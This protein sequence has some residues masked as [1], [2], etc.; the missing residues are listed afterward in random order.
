MKISK[1]LFVSRANLKGAKRKKTVLIMMVL[2]VVAV[3]V[4]V[5]YLNIAT[6]NYNIQLSSIKFRQIEVDPEVVY[7]SVSHKGVNEKT[8][9][10]VLSIDHVVSCE[11]MKYNDYQTFSYKEIKDDNGNNIAGEGSEIDL[12]ELENV[13]SEYRIDEELRVNCAVGQSLK[14]APVM[15]CIIPDKGEMWHSETN[16]VSDYDISYLYGKTLTVECPYKALVYSKADG[17][18]IEQGGYTDE[19]VEL[20]RLTLNLKVVGVYSLAE[21]GTL[22]GSGSVI[23]SPETA[24]TIEDMAVE[25]AK[26]TMPNTIKDY[27]NDPYARRYMVTVDSRENTKEVEEKLWELGYVPFIW[28]IMDSS[29]EQF[30]TMFSGGGTFLLI[31]ILMLTVINL[32][33]SVYS[34][35][36]ERRSEIGLLKAIG[37]K[38]RQIFL[39]MYLENVIQAVRALIIGGVIS[40][41]I[42]FIVNK[43]NVNDAVY[44]KRIFVMQW[45]Q[46]GILLAIAFALILIIPLTCQ[47]I[48]TA[49]ITRIQPQEAMNS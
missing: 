49:L 4:L 43:I 25:E 12:E 5:G 21:Y 37:Y 42:I 32:F 38:S 3:T 36:N 20:A 9:D 17:N 27:V 8:M 18:G 45:S 34:N 19:S 6:Y 26:K 48:M 23:V 24:Q 47:L 13:I 22:T 11:P 30:A 29:F 46:F 41:V 35:I 14:D 15:S 7:P 16:S 1:L 33:L 31:A 10:E 40:A 44:L 2:A 39:S 28:G